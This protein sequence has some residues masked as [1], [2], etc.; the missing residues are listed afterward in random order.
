VL[1][2]ALDTRLLISSCVIGKYNDQSSVQPSI[3][4]GDVS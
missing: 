3:N 4:L 1:C 2:N